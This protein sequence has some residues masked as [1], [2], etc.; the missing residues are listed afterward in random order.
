MEIEPT[1]PNQATVMKASARKTHRKTRTGCR[2]CKQRKIK[3]DEQRPAC[4]N[5]IKHSV[6]CDFLVS[7]AIGSGIGLSHTV[8]SAHTSPHASGSTPNYDQNGRAGSVVGGSLIS[9]GLNLTDLELLHNYVTSTAFTIHTDPAM[10]IAW[11]VNVPQVGF[12]YDFVM[13]GILAISALHMAHYKPDRREFYI[14][15]GM[16]QHQ[17]GLRVA[18]EV[19]AN[20]TE[21]NCTGV[22]AFSA[23]TIFFTLASPRKPGDLLLVGDNGMA[24]WLFL[25]KG[26]SFIVNSY[27]DSLRQGVLGPMF[28]AGRRQNQVRSQYTSEQSTNDDPLVE[29]SGLVAQ[30]SLDLVNKHIYLTAINTLRR[31]FAFY[32][33]PGPPGY[34][35]AD[36]FT[37][38][39]EVTEEFL[40]LLRQHTMESLTIFAYFCVILKRLDSHWWMQ[41]WSTHLV[42]RIWNLLD[43]EHRYVP[44]C[45]SLRAWSDPAQAVDP[46]AAGGDWLDSLLTGGSAAGHP[47]D[48]SARHSS[49][50]FASSSPRLF[51]RSPFAVG[52]RSLLRRRVR[53]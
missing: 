18:T 45:A 47:I 52:C 7:H 25:V 27:E 13:R 30:N 17:T 33:R 50:S 26:T 24:D 12:Q 32:E 34:E 41:G 22:Y 4:H 49:P 35:T 10:K 39:F 28:Q 21:E 36:M 2:T 20:V 11:R 44:S 1:T 31:S 6:Q 46:V 8:N 3:C 43:E 53:G 38:I 29:L 16:V 40:Q 37:W 51:S 42:S 48:P 19:L 15:Q 5:C 14:Q 9:G 23:L